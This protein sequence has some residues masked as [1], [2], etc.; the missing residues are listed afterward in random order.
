[1]E[2]GEHMTD[3][4]KMYMVLVDEV[5]QTIERLKTALSKAEDIYIDTCDD[6]A[7]E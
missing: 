1:M 3:Y 4:K 6:V 7:N 5:D 2:R